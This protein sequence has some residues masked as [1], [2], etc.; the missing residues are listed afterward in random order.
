M[1]LI[2][3]SI[4]PCLYSHSGQVSNCGKCQKCKNSM[5]DRKMQ[6]YRRGLTLLHFNKL[7]TKPRSGGPYVLCRVIGGVCHV[8]LRI[9]DRFKVIVIMNVSNIC[10]ALM[11]FTDHG[12]WKSILALWYIDSLKPKSLYT[13]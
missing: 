12:E 1:A 13:D 8:S 10:W 5:N 9:I 4:L 2:T 6:I 3:T 7:P 11:L